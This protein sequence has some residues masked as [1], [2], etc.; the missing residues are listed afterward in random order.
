MWRAQASA[1]PKSDEVAAWAA[2]LQLPR[3]AEAPLALLTLMR[4]GVGV[5]LVIR[6][7]CANSGYTT[8]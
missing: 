4:S 7:V 8:T 6:T 5:R 3:E 1:A 2:L